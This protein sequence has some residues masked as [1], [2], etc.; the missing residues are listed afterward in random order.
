MI[1]FDWLPIVQ[2]QSWSSETARLCPLAAR[3]GQFTSTSGTFGL[4]EQWVARLDCPFFLFSKILKIMFFGTYTDGRG[5]KRFKNSGKLVHRYVAEKKLG[6]KLY[7]GTVVHHRNRN[8]N[9][10]RPSNLWVF[11]SQQEHDIA[12]EIDACRFGRKAS[13]KGFGRRKRKN[14]LFL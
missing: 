8:K 7:P 12:H 6:V 2:I 1:Y 13:Y 4:R 11:N 14:D 9:D 10:N 5:Y 3:D